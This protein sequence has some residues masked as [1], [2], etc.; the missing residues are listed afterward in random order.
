MKFIQWLK[1]LFTKKE[2]EEMSDQ[3]VIAAAAEQPSTVQ[4]AVAQPAV[5]ETV[6]PAT[7]EEKSPL[8]QAKA[9]FDAFIE[10][11]EHGLEVLGEEAE[12]DLV[13]LKDKFL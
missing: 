5:A 8:E 3:S 11:V 7:V 13:A 6:Q 4:P 1:S 2:S 10:F 12:A 9:K